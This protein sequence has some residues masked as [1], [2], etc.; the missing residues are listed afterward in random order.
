[1]S[2]GP[3]RYVPPLPDV[4]A[5][6]G[7]LYCDGVGSWEDEDE[8]DLPCTFCHRRGLT[9]VLVRTVRQSKDWT[10]R[11]E[12]VLNQPTINVA[13]HYVL[14]QGTS[15]QGGGETVDTYSVRV[16]DI[17]VLIAALSAFYAEHQRTGR[18]DGPSVARSTSEVSLEETARLLDEWV[19]STEGSNQSTDTEEGVS[20]AV[21][22]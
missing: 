11:N 9:S 15:H 7:C 19:A 20:D 5:V 17:P 6:R 3:D 14:A 2:A 8:G 21:A 12:Y 10:R 22:T 13:G 16:E 18:T 1:M 4:R